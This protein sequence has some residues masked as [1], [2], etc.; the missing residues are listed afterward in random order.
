MIS[1]C[2]EPVLF[3]GTTKGRYGELLDSEGNY[4][5]PNGD[6]IWLDEETTMPLTLAREYANKHIA[7]ALLLIV[8]SSLLT[9][10]K[11]SNA[12]P[13]RGTIIIPKYW[14]TSELPAGSFVS[15]DVQKDPLRIYGTDMKQHIEGMR[16][17]CAPLGVV[18]YYLHIFSL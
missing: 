4:R 18:P 5:Y 1:E 8:K 9:L 17:L 7:S 12:L 6:D 11:P 3:H 13:T 16:T 2:H 14:V 15:Y 10:R